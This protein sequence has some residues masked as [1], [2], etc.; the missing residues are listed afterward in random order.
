MRVKFF[1]L[2]FLM[3]ANFS[4]AQIPV[5]ITFP[6]NNANGDSY[7]KNQKYD[8]IITFK[9]GLKKV[10]PGRMYK[11][12]SRDMYYIK[13]NGTKIYVDETKCIQRV[14]VD[15]LTGVA[16]GNMWLFTVMKGDIMAYSVYP[17]ENMYELT[18][19]QKGKSPLYMVLG[20][21]KNKILPELIADDSLAT[22]EWIKDHRIGWYK[23]IGPLVLTG[24]LSAIYAIFPEPNPIG[25]T[26]LLLIPIGIIVPLA[27][28]RIPAAH[29]IEIYNADKLAKKRTN[30]F[31]E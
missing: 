8:Y 5:R 1:T 25:I 21:F 27:K 16:T 7:T 3:A 31:N 22:K 23:G 26:S 14:N 11:N 4:F 9:T 20:N 10:C 19:V 15:T 29:I 6:I 13:S 24:V 2:V 18:H 30:Y 12:H 28:N 17:T